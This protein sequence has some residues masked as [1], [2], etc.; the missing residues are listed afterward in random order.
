[1]RKFMLIF[2]FLTSGENWDQIGIENWDRILTES[3]SSEWI[4]M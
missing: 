1:M 3:M 2:N 4:K